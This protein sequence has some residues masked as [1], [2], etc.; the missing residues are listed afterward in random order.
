ME[1]V[2]V[3]RIVRKARDTKAHTAGEKL[4][5][6]DPALYQAL[7]GDPGT[8]REALAAALISEAGRQ[9]FATTD[10]RTGDFLVDGTIT[11]EIGG[12]KKPRKSADFVVRDDTDVASGKTLPLWT[13]GFL[14]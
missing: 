9:L 5:F 11:I 4:F 2:G 8:E 3:V 1:S 12:A 14:Y 10:E 7:G 6:A 13:L